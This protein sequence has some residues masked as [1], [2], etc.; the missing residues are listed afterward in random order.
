MKTTD[1]NYKML[2]DEIKLIW[3]DNKKMYDYCM[4]DIKRVTQINEDGA[5][6][7]IRRHI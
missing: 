7:N 4:K 3:R 1:K 6:V 2:S 5:R